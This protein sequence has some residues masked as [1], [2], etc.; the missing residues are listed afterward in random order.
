MVP[1]L[2]PDWNLR[3]GPELESGQTQTNQDVQKQASP[4]SNDIILSPQELQKV[5]LA[6]MSE[7]AYILEA[8]LLDLGN[9]AAYVFN[10]Y[11]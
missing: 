3:S 7:K 4:S 8:V 11:M 5:A 10:R 6:E 9:N 1:T 2:D